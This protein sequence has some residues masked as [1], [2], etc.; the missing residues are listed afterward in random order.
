MMSIIVL[1]IVYLLAVIVFHYCAIKRGPR[2]EVISKG[3][4]SLI[5]VVIGC[6]VFPMSCDNGEM[7]CTFQVGII[8]G[9]VF[10]MI[11]DILLALRNINKSKRS[12]FILS[13]ICA[14]A[15]GHLSYLAVIAL[16][17]MAILPDALIWL[18]I[19]PVILGI[20]FGFGLLK[21]SPKLNLEFGKL[22]PGVFF[23]GS[24]I[25]CMLCTAILTAVTAT[26]QGLFVSLYIVPA[27]ASV[28]FVS[29]DSL[30]S[31]SYFDK[32]GEITSAKLIIA[33]HVTYYLAQ[34]LF[35]ISA[36]G[37]KFIG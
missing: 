13:G 24:L 35:A 28:L 3:I 14:F 19:L 2:S 23:Y 30:L 11:G 17:M 8:A 27:I 25:G 33:I 15:L 29:S 9:L 34:Y 10:G 7:A 5:F 6:L 37:M 18:G 32:S 22:K 1:T 31:K 12:G 16:N 21:I 26:M 20:L 36:I 4:A